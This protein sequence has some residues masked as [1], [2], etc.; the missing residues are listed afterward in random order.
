M[1][2]CLTVTFFYL[3]IF[4]SDFSGLYCWQYGAVLRGA[5]NIQFAFELRGREQHNTTDFCIVT[6]S[7][8]NGRFVEVCGRERFWWRQD[9]NHFPRTGTGER[10]EASCLVKQFARIVIS[11]M[12]CLSI[13]WRK[14]ELRFCA[15]WAS[16][17]GVSKVCNKENLLRRLSFWSWCVESLQQRESWKWTHLE[18]KLSELFSVSH[19]VERLYEKVRSPTLLP[20]S[21][22][23]NRNHWWLQV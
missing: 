19:F 8:S 6:W 14:P 7:R 23:G 22:F 10:V 2:I 12:M 11:A 18:I 13:Q 16:G 17:R 20:K 9:T 5:T 3:F 21:F 4:C 15:G 1:F